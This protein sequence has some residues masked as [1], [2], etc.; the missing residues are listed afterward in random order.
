[1]SFLEATG[2]M[3]IEKA[4]NEGARKSRRKVATKESDSYYKNFR[5]LVI[6]V[7]FS[8]V[9]KLITVA[10]NH[11]RGA[12]GL[13]NSHWIGI[14]WH[15]RRAKHRHQADKQQSKFL[16]CWVIKNFGFYIFKPKPV[17][18][19]GLGFKNVAIISKSG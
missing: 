12:I 5:G 11:E 6:L 4:N 9:I 15:C 2:K 19:D 3:L 1:V 8:E 14:C 18:A 13:C 7:N 10:L 17:I 16:H